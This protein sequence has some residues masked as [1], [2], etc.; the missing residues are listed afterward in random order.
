MFADNCNNKFSDLIVCRITSTH[1]F[2]SLPELLEENHEPI[3]NLWELDTI[4]INP[5]AVVKED[6]T[7]Y[8]HYVDSVEFKEGKYYVKLPWK[9]DRPFLFNN[10]RKSLGQLYSLRK[11]LLK[12]IVF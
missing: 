11:N 6:V 9:S 7:A 10:Y 5:N 4:G 1:S 3:H 8:Q 12:K 2:Q